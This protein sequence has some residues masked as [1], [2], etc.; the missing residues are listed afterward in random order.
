MELTVPTTS[1]DE[2]YTG[3]QTPRGAGGP[4]GSVLF[5]RKYAGGP[6]LQRSK[7]RTSEGHGKDG[8]GAGTGVASAGDRDG[9]GVRRGTGG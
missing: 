2:N 4:T 7:C 8:A 3:E 6:L 5:G 1:V 9:V